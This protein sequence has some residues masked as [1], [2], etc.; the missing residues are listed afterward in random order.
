MNLRPSSKTE[1]A[2]FLAAANARRARIGTLD[3]RA[4]NRV[5][6]YTPEDLTVT[7]ESGVTLGQ[8]QRLLG[9]KRQWLPVDPPNPES[10]TI[11]ELIGGNTSGP[12]RFGFGTVRD[13]L[14]GLQV[15]LADGRLVRSGGR[16]VK[17]V[18]GFDVMKLFVG[19]G[20]SLGIIVEAA[21]KLLPLPEAER[22]V[23]RRCGSVEDASAAIERV[24]NSPLTPS[25]LDLHNVGQQDGSLAVVLGFSG[26][27]EEVE[28][29]LSRAAEMDFRD[30]ATLGYEETFWRESSAP[31][32]VSVLPSRITEVIRQLGST[33]FVARAGNGVIYHRGNPGPSATS[34]E[35]WLGRR[36]KDTFDPNGILSAMPGS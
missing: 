3:L 19:G 26:T 9:G 16:V 18:A 21:F 24:I 31:H 1:I 15:V 30:T 27:T 7:V 13:H 23:M 2:G 36:L 6:E 29:Q 34:G 4:M 17:N 32:R 25:V 10:V 35:S 11:A 22:F 12:R 14:I 28:W 8:L 20:E 5:L 33:S